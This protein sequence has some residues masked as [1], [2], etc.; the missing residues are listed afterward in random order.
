MPKPV[1]KQQEARAGQVS[2]K[3]Q[4]REMVAEHVGGVGS[5][6]PSAR[7]EWPFPGMWELM[8][9]FKGRTHTVWCV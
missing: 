2:G 6:S 3:D 4:A 9:G 7:L 5:G 1:K 8:Q